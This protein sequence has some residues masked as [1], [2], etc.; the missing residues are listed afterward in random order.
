MR[1]ISSWVFG[2]GAPVT[3]API[4]LVGV[5]LV[6]AGAFVACS[7]SSS[8]GGGGNDAGVDSSVNDTLPPPSDT[9]PKDDSGTDDT[10]ETPGDPL[11]GCT[12]DPGAPTPDGG[13]PIDGGFSSDA[14][15]NPIDPTTL[16]IDE[17]MA[18]FP[19]STGTLTA[20]IT[21]EMGAIVC[22]L[23]ETKAPITVANFV[24]LARGT[25]PALRGTTT[26]WTWTHFY[27]GLKWHRVIPDFVIQGGDP[28]GNGTGG[29]GYDLPNEN[30]ATEPTGTL[31]MAASTAPSGSQFYIV[32]G[33]GPAANYNVFGTCTTD[34]A[35]AIAGVPRTPTDMPKT[36]V[37]MQSIEIARCP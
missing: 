15:T 21:T 35:I 24:G 20:V 22:Q 33:A 17:A 14:S 8:D 12:R 27:D 2:L 13:T 5:A 32:V 26:T 11:A 34:V 29:P 19:S 31:A 30:H 4:V 36:P 25:R 6:G 10:N 16:T 23:D 3:L 28:L 18:G 37:H 1:R 9:T 7:S